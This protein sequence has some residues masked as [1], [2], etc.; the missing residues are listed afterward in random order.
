M[1]IKFS[2]F[3]TMHE[4]IRDEVLAKMK[5]VY[6][7]QWFIGGS[8]CDEFEKDFATYCGTTYAVGCGNGLDAIYLILKAMG[9]GEGDEVIVPSHTF[10]ATSLAVNYVGAKVRFV[11]V[12]EKRYTI[13]PTLIEEAI[14]PATKAI[15]AVHLYGQ[16][17]DMEPIMEIAKKYNLK[18]IEDAAQA[19]GA[20]YKEKRV[21]NLGHAAAFSF[22]PGKNLGALGDGGAITTNDEMLAKKIKAIGNYGSEKK[23]EHIYLGTNSRLDTIQAAI[24]RIKLK[25]LDQWND[26][27]KNIAKN[28][29]EGIKTDKVILPQKFCDHVWH[30]FVVR[31]KN[32]AHFQKYLESKEI[33]TLIHYPTPIH[34]Q[35]AYQK[36]NYKKG[37]YPIAEQIAEEVVSLPMYYGMTQQEVQYVIDTINDYEY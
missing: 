20:Y 21:G 34:L 5:D 3:K 36:Y 7:A 30:L 33:S 37:E 13:D 19:H 35:K 29:L 9:I 15:I 8:E 12:E 14:T 32:R 16:P 27:R 26:Y 28:Y 24:L 22:Y 2:E 4:E 6:D 1:K 31:V 23:Y 17:A 11:E 25:H 10:I 18:V